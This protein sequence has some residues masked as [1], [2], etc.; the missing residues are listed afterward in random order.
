MSPHR[1]P[2]DRAIARRIA[3]LAIAVGAIL[4]APTSARADESGTIDH[5]ETVDGE[6]RLTYSLPVLPDGVEPDLDS[7][8]VSVNDEPADA[9]AALVSD[10]TGSGATIARTT[11]LTIDVSNSMRGERFEQAKVA[12]KAFLETAPPD[13]QVG[14]VTFASD[15][16]TVQEPTLD[17]AKLA[18][19]V[20]DLSLSADTRLYDGVIEAVTTGEVDGQRSLLVLSDGKDTSKTPLGEVTTAIER[21]EIKVDVVALEQSGSARVPLEEM[22]TAGNGALLGADD[23]E[24]LVD[25]FSDEAAAL[26]NQV[27]VTVEVPGSITEPEGTVAVSVEAD[28]VIYTDSAFVTLEPQAA[29]GTGAAP[30]R[31]TPSLEGAAPPRFEI[32]RDLLLAGVVAAGVGTL[33]ILLTALG[34]LDRKKKV[35][36]EDRVS[37]YTRDGARGPGR[38]VPGRGSAEPSKSVTVSAVGMAQR[39]LETNKGLESAL[40]TRLDSAGMSLKP[41]EWLLLHAGIAVGAAV[42]GFL[43][44]GGNLVLVGILF[45]VGVV[46]PWI[47]L[48]MKRRRRLKAFDGHLADT[49]QLMSGS[50]SAGLSLAQS[51]DTVV[52]EGTQPISGEFRRAIIEARLG[53]Q[54]EDALDSIAKRMESDDF[55]WIVMAI[56]IQREVGG[57]LAELLLKV[58]ST[59]R[60]REYLRRQVKSLSAEGKLSAYIIGGLPPAFVVYLTI[61]NPDYLDPLLQTGI[62][63]VLIGVMCGL[64]LVGSFWMSRVVKVNV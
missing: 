5:A 40:G 59:M 51:V 34:V 7:V 21:A 13:V 23:P 32:S 52:R 44:G 56:R 30:P 2:A 29:T 27:L 33:L 62:G 55:A 8:E 54:I 49:L 64:M 58:A 6:L 10:G 63:W 37:A 53:V 35:T 19:V 28:G 45:A 9:S 12:A 41:A 46:L 17:R 1:R 47:Y 14:V 48:G 60:E 22:A 25:L 4:L 61:V 3:G 11:I 16:E 39:A 15:V 43:M 18:A 42:V 38:A 26:A 36:L 24:A 50:L 20:D 57:N 31:T